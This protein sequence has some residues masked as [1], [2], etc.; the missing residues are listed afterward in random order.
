M[1]PWAGHARAAA[2]SR[3]GG[4]AV[5]AVAP[6]PRGQRG[7][8]RIAPPGTHRCQVSPAPAT[9]DAWP[10]SRVAS[11][12]RSSPPSS[13]SRARPATV[14]LRGPR[15]GRLVVSRRGP[16]RDL[17]RGA[18]GSQERR[19]TARRWARAGR[20]G[21]LAAWAWRRARAAR[22]ARSL[23]SALVAELARVAAASGGLPMLALAGP[24]DHS[25]SRRT[26]S[27]ATGGSRAR[28]R[29]AACPARARRA[30]AS[31]ARTA[32]RPAR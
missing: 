19:E 12:H 24:M 31:Q 3:H 10:R 25:F 29:R 18:T 4:R 9:K 13:R 15:A 14:G 7:R 11:R 32:S 21:C 8:R 6:W 23:P 20:S 1:S 27:G 5:R 16:P 22:A 30:T 26:G 28:S 17:A 2:R